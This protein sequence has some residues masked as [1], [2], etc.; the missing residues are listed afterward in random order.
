MNSLASL[1]QAGEERFASIAQHDEQP[2]ATSSSTEAPE[3]QTEI[4]DMLLEQFNNGSVLPN[5]L[6]SNG[7]FGDR[8]SPADQP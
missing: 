4:A 5:V 2:F 8:H 6:P 1:I 7:R 3:T